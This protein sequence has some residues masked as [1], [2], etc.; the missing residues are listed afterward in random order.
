M[1]NNQEDFKIEISEA[2]NDF[3][4]RTLGSKAMLVDAEYTKLQKDLDALYW[5]VRKR[6]A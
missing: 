4:V 5:D 6:I 3:L 1:E 2:I